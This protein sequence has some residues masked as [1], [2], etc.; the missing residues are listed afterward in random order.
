MTVGFFPL[1][2]INLIEKLKMN[3]NREY[4]ANLSLAEEESIPGG[5]FIKKNISTAPRMALVSTSKITNHSV[6]I[7]TL[8]LIPT[9]TL[10]QF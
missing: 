4:F 9:S 10:T 1:K 5:G 8:I 7:P 6:P 3:N 2:R